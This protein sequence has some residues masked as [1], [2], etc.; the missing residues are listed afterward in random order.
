M[1]EFNFL[2]CHDSGYNL[3]TYVS[4]FSFLKQM[5]NSE[6]NIYILHKE[7]ETFNEYKDKLKKFENINKINL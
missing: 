6:L 2:Y 7:P 5:K 3:Q 1:R 4:I